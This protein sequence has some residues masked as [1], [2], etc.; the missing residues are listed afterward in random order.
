MNDK[1]FL[2]H[3]GVKGMKWGKRKSFSED[4]PSNDDVYK[5]IKNYTKIT[6]PGAHKEAALKKL[7]SHLNS[8]PYKKRVEEKYGTEYDLMV[9][10]NGL[11]DTEKLFG[12]K[13]RFMK[14]VFE[15]HID[16]LFAKAEDEAWNE[17]DEKWR[18]SHRMTDEDFLEHYGKLGMKWGKR[19]GVHPPVPGGP[20]KRTVKDLTDDELKKKISRLQMEKQYKDL[21][22]KDI[23]RG[24]KLAEN[25]LETSLKTVGTA[26]VVTLLKKS[27]GSVLK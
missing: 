16:R 4:G 13:E 15:Q 9:S 5:A 10:K 27:L 24:R 21:S 7:N 18:A 8:E 2:Q 3:Y 6:S 22:K 23:G 11:Q 14:D 19:K 1:E 25:V 12:K 17:R 26:L 20:K